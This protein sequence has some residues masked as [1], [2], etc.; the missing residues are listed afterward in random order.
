M[1]GKTE[2]WHLL[3]TAQGAEIMLGLRPGT[4]RERFAA[5]VRAGT[6]LEVIARQPASPGDTW[7]IP[8]G[9][10]HALG[11]GIFLYEVQ[12][13]S[14]ITYRVY[15][16]DR[17]A[18]AA[19]ELHLEQAIACVDPAPPVRR[20]GAD[21]VN[22]QPARL[23]TCPYFALDRLALAPGEQATL[24]T[25]G[26]TFHAL[27]AVAGAAR[28]EVSGASLEIAACATALVPACVGRYEVGAEGGAT[29]MI[30]SAEN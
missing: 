4:D 5:A 15:D 13:A 26:A 21:A 8:A 16:W 10:V 17:P 28:I 2:A 27:T 18:S 30:A 19:R 20:V 11:P 7:F 25:G 9:T 3:A 12:Q 29:L 6:T 22:T 14:D 1:V 24:D 23:V